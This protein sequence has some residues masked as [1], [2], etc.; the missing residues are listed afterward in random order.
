MKYEEIYLREHATIPEVHAGL[1]R[2]MA[3]YNEWRPHQTLGNLTPRDAY[4]AEAE[5]RRGAEATEAQAA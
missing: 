4:T 3:R 5:P 1:E 2:W